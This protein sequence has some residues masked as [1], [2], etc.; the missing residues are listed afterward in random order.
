[1][2]TVTTTETGSASTLEES[3]LAYRILHLGFTVAPILF[4]LDKFFGL[5][6]DWVDF[7]PAFVTETVSGSV[8][9]GVVGV[10]EI[11]AGIGV[12]LRPKIF[13]PVVAAWLGVIIITLTISGGFWD[14]AL[15]DF[16]LLLAA[17]ALWRLARAHAA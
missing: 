13:A 17:L 2:T 14:I 4:G 15:R 16:G 10:I 6:T 12:W 5:M 11:A 3:R 9:M 7:L 8:V 1:M